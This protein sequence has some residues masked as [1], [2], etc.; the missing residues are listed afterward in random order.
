MIV[1]ELATA[2]SY[3]VYGGLRK[4]VL[5]TLHQLAKTINRHSILLT[6]FVSR[7]KPSACTKTM[8]SH[9]TTQRVNESTS[10][11]STIYCSSN[12]LGCQR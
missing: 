10:L 5:I 12:S 7:A 2:S 1:I 8:Y 3:L 6:F 11:E 9:S 4:E